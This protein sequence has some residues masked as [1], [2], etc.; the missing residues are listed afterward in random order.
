MVVNN[1]L[2]LPQPYETNFTANS[3]DVGRVKAALDRYKAPYQ[4][5]DGANL[6]N[7]IDYA[8]MYPIFYFDLN[9]VKDESF[10]T[11]G[12]ADLEVVTKCSNATAVN[13]FCVVLHKRS[14]VISGNSTQMTLQQL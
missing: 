2:A 3:V 6:I 10:S 5:T 11:E 4:N 14:A 7:L 8:N 1:K 9:Q 12:A 13:F